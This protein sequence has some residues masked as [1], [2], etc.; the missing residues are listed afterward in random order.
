MNEERRRKIG[1]A[2]KGKKVIV[3]EA[4]RKKISE[5]LKGKIPKNLS[6]LHSLQYNP[7][8]YKKMV[9]TRLL[10]DGYRQSEE[11][12][13]KISLTHKGKKPT[14]ETRKK[15]SQNNARYW[16]GKKRLDMT[17]EKNWNY[18]KYGSQHTRYQENKL[19]SLRKIIRNSE[20][21]RQYKRMVL[22]R[23]KFTCI[24]CKRKSVYLE[25][26]HYPKGFSELLKQNN[27]INIDEAL[28]CENLWNINNGRTLCQSCHE[29]TENFPKQL[30]GKRKKLLYEMGLQK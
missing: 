16:L 28:N 27:I 6:Y 10:K 4:T 29:K 8:R 23:D 22:E 3:T 15:L 7:E 30:I 17:G 9:A 18:G 20:K 5:S 14:E 11:A 13:R 19:S 26:D 12:K 21:Y 2:N 24:M 25:L 1:L